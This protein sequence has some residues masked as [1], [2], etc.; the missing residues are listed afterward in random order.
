M[1]FKFLNATPEQDFDQ[2]IRQSTLAAIRKLAAKQQTGET[3]RKQMQL[4]AMGIDPDSYQY[5]TEMYQLSIR[6]ENEL[7][8]ITRTPCTTDLRQ[9]A[10]KYIP[11]DT[12]ENNDE[13]Q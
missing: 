6:Q 8:A 5:V 11:E 9:L 3:L 2:M 1:T 12:E 4:K 13:Q 10:D 7:G